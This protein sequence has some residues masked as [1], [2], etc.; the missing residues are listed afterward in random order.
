[1]AYNVENKDNMPRGFLRYYS[2]FLEKK[3]FLIDTTSHFGTTKMLQNA[4]QQKLI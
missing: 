3:K 4:R 1:M 2:S